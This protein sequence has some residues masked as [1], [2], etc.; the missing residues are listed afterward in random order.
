MEE[1][2]KKKNGGR[3]GFP[4]GGVEPMKRMMLSIMELISFCR[5]AFL[6]GGVEGLLG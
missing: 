3:A 6:K 5:R 4:E 1:R 2:G